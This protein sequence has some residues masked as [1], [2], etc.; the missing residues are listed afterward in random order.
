MLEKRLLTGNEVDIVFIIDRHPFPDVFDIDTEYVS[1]K[2]F[3][4]IVTRKDKNTGWGVQLKLKGFLAN[5]KK[6][7]VVV[8]PSS[9]N[10]KILENNVEVPITKVKKTVRGAIPKRVF[11]ISKDTYP[12]YLEIKSASSWKQILSDHEYYLCQSKDNDLLQKFKLI[13]TYGGIFCESPH[14]CKSIISKT[15]KPSQSALVVH[16]GDKK[17]FSDFL[18]MFTRQHPLLKE[19]LQDVGDSRD[20]IL[21]KN[22]WDQIVSDY[23]R[24][25][26]ADIQVIE[27]SYLQQ[28]LVHVYQ[29]K[30]LQDLVNRSK[31]ASKAKHHSQI[32]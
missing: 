1:K 15:I 21:I 3:R 16:M 11:Q 26:K 17:T 27:Y 32:E 30:Q 31:Q 14:I 2:R 28:R 23:L 13:Y 25:K 20:R 29:E 5:G 18:F 6:I 9:T 4:I 10:Q 19:F 24:S 7:Q 22:R 12:K 8:G